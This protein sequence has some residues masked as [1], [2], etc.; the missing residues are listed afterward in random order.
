[1]PELPDVPEVPEEPEVPLEAAFSLVP[2]SPEAFITKV[3][4]SDPWVVRPV[5]FILSNSADDPLV[6]TLFQFGIL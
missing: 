1:V 2:T 3:V 5:N 6:T 4:F